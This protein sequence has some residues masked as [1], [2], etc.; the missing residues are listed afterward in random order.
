MAMA[1]RLMDRL[2]LRFTKKE[3]V[4]QHGWDS[5]LVLRVSKMALRYDIVVRMRFNMSNTTPS[6]RPPNHDFTTSARI[7]AL[8]PKG[9]KDKD[10]AN[11]GANKITRVSS[12]VFGTPPWKFQLA[13]HRTKTSTLPFMVVAKKLSWGGPYGWALI[14]WHWT[15]NHLT[16]HICLYPSPELQRN[17]SQGI[18]KAV[19]DMT[20]KLEPTGDRRSCK[21]P[22]SA[23][24]FPSGAFR[25]QV[26]E[27]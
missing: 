17:P 21:F 20:T 6:Y 27:Y 25:L 1:W 11:Y 18:S 7:S 10:E 2:P 5:R 19:S 12:Y 4:T 23:G 24:C 9:P 8:H 22:L 26:V 14:L 16:I 13:R 3:P 15:K